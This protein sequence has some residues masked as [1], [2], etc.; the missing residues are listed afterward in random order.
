MTTAGTLRP[1][2]VRGT[3]VAP[4]PRAGQH[5]R[6]S[7]PSPLAAAQQRALAQRNAGDPAGAREYLDD[8]L[9][10]AR[11]SYGEDHPEV[12]A[13]SHFLA[14]LHRES[15]D[16]AAARRILEIALEAA[17][18]RT[19]GNDP[20]VLGITAD[21]AGVAEELGNRHEARKHHT[22]IATDGP[23]VLGAEHWAVQAAR[24]FLG[25]A[26]PAP[27]GQTQAGSAGPAAPHA[28]QPSA[29]QSA[30]PAT[31]YSA[32]PAAPQSAPPATP[33]S[34]PPA[35]PQ[36]AAAGGATARPVSPALD[37][38]AEPT[39]HLTTIQID[40]PTTRPAPA[41]TGDEATTVLS[42]S[43]P[44]P[45]GPGQ[46]QTGQPADTAASPDPDEP[47][48]IVA[49]A[50]TSDTGAEATT[51]MPLVTPPQQQAPSQ[52]YAAPAP[53]PQPAQQY[54]APIPPQA[55]PAQSQGWSP[56]AQNW[57]PT[58]APPVSSPPI[59]SPP[60]S[61][62]PISSPPGVYAYPPGP[63]PPHFAPPPRPA[64]QPGWN[65]PGPDRPR[66][67]ERREQHPYADDSA[68]DRPRSRGLIVA[69]S[70]LAAVALV[71]V[72]AAI[73]LVIGK[74]G[75]EPADPA[76]TPSAA[77]LG[78]APTNV[79]LRDNGASITIT[80]DDPS[81]GLVSFIIAGG[82]NQLGRVAEVPAGQTS[83]TLQGLSP[84]QDYCFQVLAVYAVDNVASSGPVCTSR[85]A[86][87]TP[88]EAMRVKPPPVVIW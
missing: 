6:V 33:Y 54:V 79:Q 23:S 84:S 22:R 55:P 86:Q 58:S 82:P 57:A 47:T 85:G 15:D 30:P 43:T 45:V 61:S 17:S 3:R 18:R 83:R 60:I 52:S 81:G 31:P 28:P 36:P 21:L 59:S 69:V 1:T 11:R 50:G 26:A 76:P 7:Q 67:G 16:P 62:P 75:D 46:V 29:P 13:A 72:V 2:T 10:S 49:P 65:D 87:P 51:L 88:S 44:P 53:P 56:Q 80:W 35:A 20:L 74:L 14:R 64:Q 8:V 66:F 25:D 73:V 70:I 42:V 77:P 38:L 41:E 40:E 12:L 27:T 34:A 9:S 71:A 19:A 5:G 68:A 32:P 37:A 63:H 39:T 24:A 4:G 78:A 48:M